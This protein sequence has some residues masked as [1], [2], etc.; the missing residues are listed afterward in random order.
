MF[1]PR[2]TSMRGQLVVWYL[3]V[4]AVLLFGLG[5][6][7]T[8][9]LASYLQS[10]TRNGI[11]N[12]AEAELA[13]LGPCFI[14]T[15]DDLFLKAQSLAE[16]LG[17]PDTAVKIVTRNG[18]ALA[19]HG[20]GPPGK[21]RVLQLTA[22]DI[23]DLTGDTSSADPALPSNT[24]PTQC[25]SSIHG[26]TRSKTTSRRR[27]PSETHVMVGSQ[28]T[29]LVAIPLGSRDKVIGYAIL[30]NSLADS[31][32][33]V[34]RA[35]LAF[36]IGALIAFLLAAMVALPIIGHALQPLRRVT[37]T[38]E[39]I[40]AGDLEQRAHLARSH[41]EVGRLGKAFDA[42]VDR[43]QSALSDARASEE[44]MRRFLAD[45]SHEFR[46]PVT[47]LRGTAQVLLRQAAAEEPGTRSALQ[48]MHEE[49]VRLSRLV[50]DLLTLSR[51]DA[52]TSLHPQVVPL[53]RCIEEFVRR[54]GGVWPDRALRVE[55]SMS[56][57]VA[58]YVDPDSLIR[59]LTNLVDNAA[60]YS[61][62]AGAI[63][64]AGSV[65]TDRVTIAVCDDGPGL[66]PEDAERMFERFYRASTS[67]SR[68]SGGTGLGLSIVNA[69]IQQSGGEVQVETGKDR[70]TAVIL[71]LPR[72]FV[73]ADIAPSNAP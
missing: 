6:F 72:A 49:A 65:D 39:A 23:T 20:I 27:T 22:T 63:T 40:A 73:T 36:A 35:R 31:D 54:Y 52:G 42:M 5:T 68:Q 12:A 8:V 19:D 50:D 48:D 13:V 10:T 15:E 3:S 41:D 58:V 1:R 2:L 4:L 67:R 47:V 17:S 37:T 9:T 34:R 16:L 11:R 70:G 33:T 61:A 66:A 69:L 46:T 30:G 45:A 44:R 24:N 51:L 26:S 32:A 14:H 56:G 57:E 38:A 43:L 25:K 71:T 53:R 60:R 21:T 18:I 59:V 62:P 64:I 7:Q 29:L 55:L 28:D